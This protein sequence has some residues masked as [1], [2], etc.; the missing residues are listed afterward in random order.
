MA[1]NT[2]EHLGLHLWEPTDQ[3][4]RTEF[5][6]NWQKIDTAAAG[7]REDL[8]QGLEEI[9]AAEQRHYVIGSY[10]GNG[11]TQSITLGFQPSFVIITA[12]PA[13]SR[14]TAFIAISGG[15]EAASTLSFT[16]T[17][18]TVMVTPTSYETY[19]LTNQNGTFYHYLALR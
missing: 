14:D 11:G 16:E 9:S 3:V 17:G 1:T 15:S 8:T 7:L 2:S 4:L 6:E 12:Q 13:N 18:F 19:P 10:T 5:N